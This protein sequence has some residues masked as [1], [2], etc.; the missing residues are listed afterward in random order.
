[1]TKGKKEELKK[2]WTRYPHYMWSGVALFEGELIS[3]HKC[4]SQD[5]MLLRNYDDI[6][7]KEIK[8]THIKCSIKTIEGRKREE[9]LKNKN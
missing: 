7:R 6:V 4:I 8:W 5:Y 1:M 3:E 2:P 9:D